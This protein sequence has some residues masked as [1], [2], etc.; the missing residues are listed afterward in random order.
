MVRT[1]ED[2]HFGSIEV[3]GLPIRFSA[4]EPPDQEPL[5]PLLGQHNGEILQ[6]VLSLSDAE[7]QVLEHDGILLSQGSRSDTQS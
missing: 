2:P 1:V 7:I 4:Y 5:A 3:T 6:E